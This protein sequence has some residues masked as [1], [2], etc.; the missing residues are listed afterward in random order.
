MPCGSC[1]NPNPPPLSLYT[2]LSLDTSARKHG[3]DLWNCGALPRGWGQAHCSSTGKIRVGQHVGQGEAWLLAT[4]QEKTL[5]PATSRGQLPGW[6]GGRGQPGAGAPWGARCD[7]SSHPWF[8]FRSRPPRTSSLG[9]RRAVRGKGPV[10]PWG[11]GGSHGL[12]RIS[13]ESQGFLRCHPFPAGHGGAVW[14]VRASVHTRWPGRHMLCVCP[15]SWCLWCQDILEGRGSGSPLSPMLPATERVPLG[16][17]WTQGVALCPGAPA[18]DSVLCKPLRPCGLPR[19]LSHSCCCYTDRE[20]EARGRIFFILLFSVNQYSLSHRSRVR[21]DRGPGS[22]G[23]CVLHNP[24]T[25][26]AGWDS[27]RRGWGP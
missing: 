24:S 11:G 19:W 16:G 1:S 14:V 21:E 22:Y 3:G 25:T 6:G 10:G 4:A 26:L 15:A 8:C 12:T 5:T 2:A 20:T 18:P 23:Q 27:R 7:P 13:L 17:N 9:P